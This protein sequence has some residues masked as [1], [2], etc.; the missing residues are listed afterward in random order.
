MAD[1]TFSNGTVVEVDWAQDTNDHVYDKGAVAHHAAS[2]ISVTPTG[3]ITATT[4]QAAL[5][6]LDSEKAA[7][8]GATFTGHII[9]PSGATGTQVPQAGA[10]VPLVG[11]AARLPNWTTAGRP[12]S[13]SIG[14]TGLNTTLNMKETW[15]GTYWV[16]EGWVE[17]G[18]V[19]TASGASALLS[20]I[21]SWPNELSLRVEGLSISV[22][23]DVRIRLG[24][25]GGLVATGYLGVS[26]YVNNASATAG[27]IRTTGIFLET[28]ASFSGNGDIILRKRGTVWTHNAGIA[29]N[30]A[31]GFTNSGGRVDIAGVLTQIEIAAV[32]G[33]LD[34]GT[35]YLM[36]RV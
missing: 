7:L 14:D 11:G 34:A 35:V 31:G 6:E 30:G 19:S 33:A 28:A 17:I 21:P 27:N 22:A 23:D 5:A 26:Q 9:V 13:P 3:N 10:V 12:A 2:R 20:S 16:P 29:D 32:T 18:S 8:A 4:A 15:N 1:T 25:S 24:T 36:G